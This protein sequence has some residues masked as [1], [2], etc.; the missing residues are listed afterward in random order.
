[1][2]GCYHGYTK[3]MAKHRHLDEEAAHCLHMMKIMVEMMMI[4]YG[5]DMMVTKLT[6]MMMIDDGGG[7]SDD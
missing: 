6:K 7:S 2:E 5:G 3:H 1:M 4:D